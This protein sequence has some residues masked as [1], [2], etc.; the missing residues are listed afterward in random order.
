MAGLVV[1]LNEVTVQPTPVKAMFV[2]PAGIA[3]VTVIEPGVETGPA[4]ALSHTPAT[5]SIFCPGWKVVP[6]RL[7][8]GTETSGGTGGVGVTN[9]FTLTI[10]V[11]LLLVGSESPGVFVLTPNVNVAGLFPGVASVVNV[12]LMETAGKQFPADNGYV[13][14]YVAVYVAGLVVELNTVTVQPVPT[15]VMLVKPAGMV[16]LSVIEFAVVTGPAL[17]LSHTSVMN[18]IGCPGWNVVPP[19][20]PARTERSGGVGVVNGVTVTVSV[21]ELSFKF[22]SPG[23]FA[24]NVMPKVDDVFPGVAAVVNVPVILT[25]GVQVP[26][27]MGYEPV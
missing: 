7:P 5:Y 21:V 18:V 27:A 2:K 11:A 24:V 3:P 1:E 22:G 23:V 25:G 10:S 16:P 19:R 14:V 12:P 9:G 20:L 26:G 15:T 13:P 17:A 4:A 8:E 6:L